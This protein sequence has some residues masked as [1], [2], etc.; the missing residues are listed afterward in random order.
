MRVVLAAGVAGLAAGALVVAFKLQVRQTALFPKG[1]SG[2]VVLDLSRSVDA[3]ALSRTG[4]VI[5]RI[6][7]ADA[8]VGVVVFSD[9]AY[10]LVPP[11]TPGSVIAPMLR[12][13]T[14]YDGKFLKNPWAPAFR[15][16][17]RIST[18][19]ALARYLVKR[20]H[21]EHGSVLLV[22]DL[23]TASSDQ[24]AL[25]RE[26]VAFRE[27]KVPLKVVP[28]GPL[29]LDRELFSRIL[30]KHAFVASTAPIYAPGAATAGFKSIET[31]PVGLL[32][33]GGVLLL[34]LAANELLFCPL[35]L[36]RRQA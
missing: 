25:T 33:A 21:I 15:A 16:G 18:G 2:V 24:P 1:S 23:Q 32:V 27:G 7:A 5:R 17:T 36:P 11:R 20:D 35:E 26:L 3:A 30:G 29:T 34:L 22:S 14:R 13:F 12:Y 8:P 19:L 31:L 28:L 10:E 6:V 9:I 4:E